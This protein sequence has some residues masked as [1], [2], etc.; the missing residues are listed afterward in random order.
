MED[1]IRKKAID[2]VSNSETTVLSSI[3]EGGYPRAVTMSNIKTEGIETI[4]F[5]TGKNSAK[6]KHYE[7][8][9]KAGVCYKDGG[10][11]ITLVGSVQIVDDMNIKK[12]LWLDWFIDHFPGGM[13]DPNYCVL[14]F[15]TK[16]GVLWIDNVFEEFSING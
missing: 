14:K 4:W 10:N 12:A 13:T 16:Q 8:N 7:K 15:D 6:V 2:I 1:I 11:G 5:A 9:N 3:N